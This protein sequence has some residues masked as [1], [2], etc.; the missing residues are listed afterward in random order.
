[1]DS[2]LCSQCPLWFNCNSQRDTKAR[3]FEF[4]FGNDLPAFVKE[5]HLG[6]SLKEAKADIQDFGALIDKG[7]N[8]SGPLERL[9]R[10]CLQSKFSGGRRDALVVLG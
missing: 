8:R 1:M 3:A 4:T 5:H 9:I 2:S 6:L 7:S 10:H